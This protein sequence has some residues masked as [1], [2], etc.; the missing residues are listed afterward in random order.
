MSYDSF[1][2]FLENCNCTTT[3]KDSAITSSL[4]SSNFKA[5]PFTLSENDGYKFIRT[6]K[7]EKY[8]DKTQ[9]FAQE[10]TYLSTLYHVDVSIYWPKKG[11][12]IDDCYE[13]YGDGSSCNLVQI[14]LVRSN[15]A[16]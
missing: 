3:Q 16:F 11:S 10:G 15:R 2:N 6:I 5:G 4:F 9:T 12:K 7:V 8:T 13:S 14:P 1:K